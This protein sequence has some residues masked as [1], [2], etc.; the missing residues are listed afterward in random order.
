[1]GHQ[2]CSSELPKIYV[3]RV[4]ADGPPEDQYRFVEALSS[5]VRNQLGRQSSEL[6]SDEEAAELAEPALL[7]I[8]MRPLSDDGDLE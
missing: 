1:M 3:F 2:L 8:P 7:E 6:T 5:E 4:E